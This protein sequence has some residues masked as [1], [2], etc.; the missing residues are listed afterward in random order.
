MAS[1]WLA[2]SWV[3]PDQIPKLTVIQAFT[4]MGLVIAVRFIENIYTNSIAG[5]QRQVLQNVVTSIMATLSGLGAV[6]ILV[7]VSPTIEA[8]FVW[9]GLISLATAVVFMA[10]CLPHTT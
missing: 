1:G 3:Q 5:L 6:G 7:W 2:T 10:R 8:F 4:L 9:Q